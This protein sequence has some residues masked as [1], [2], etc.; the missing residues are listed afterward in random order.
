M[1]LR[2]VGQV[3]TERNTGFYRPLG[4]R[5]QGF[6][7]GGGWASVGSARG[8]FQ[9]KFGPKLPLVPAFRG[10]QA[11]KVHFRCIC[12]GLPFKRFR[13]LVPGD[14]QKFPSGVR[15]PQGVR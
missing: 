8:L 13:S 12:N 14:P 11:P 9:S 1:V 6:L 2:C 4:A 7:G 15:Q 10:P 5:D 3:K